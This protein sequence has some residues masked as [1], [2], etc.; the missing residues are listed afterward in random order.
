[1]TAKT[2]TLEPGQKATQVMIGTPDTLIWGDLVTREKT[3][4]SAYSHLGRRVCAIRRPGP[5]PPP[6]PVPPVQK[7]RHV[8]GDLFLWRPSQSAARKRPGT[9]RLDPVGIFVRP[10]R[11]EG[12]IRNVLLTCTP[13]C[14]FKRCLH[15]VYHHPPPSLAERL[16]HRPGPGAAKP[17][18]DDDDVGSSPSGSSTRS[19]PASRSTPSTTPVTAG[20]RISRGLFCGGWASLP[21]TTYISW[22]ELYR[23]SATWP[24]FWPL[25]VHTSSPM[26]WCS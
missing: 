9:R 20:I 5:I 22:A 23:I 3:R 18:D 2:Y 4:I 19:R 24:R 17:D 15:F 26:I 13:C 25:A 16:Y 6:A 10:Y 12:P 8:A 14:W 21:R 11:P 7:P 1:M